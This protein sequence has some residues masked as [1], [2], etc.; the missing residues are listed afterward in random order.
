MSIPIKAERPHI[1]YSCIQR[2][3]KDKKVERNNNKD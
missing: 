3:Q 1:T 2:K